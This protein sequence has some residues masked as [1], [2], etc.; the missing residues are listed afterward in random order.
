[1]NE[2][3]RVLV[4]DDDAEIRELLASTLRSRSLEVDRAHD[5]REALAMMRE[6]QYAVVLLD[7]LMP[8]MNGF[9]VLD[10]MDEQTRPV[11][12]VITGADQSTVEQLDSR[13]VHGVVRKPFDPH[14]LA[15]VVR[16]CAE[17]RGRGPLGAM[18]IATV[19]AGT[20]LFALISR[21]Q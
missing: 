13:I 15:E 3:K 9:E 17:I 10:E 14:E 6:N 18:A 8:E 2:Q 16:S 5:G 1:M 11:V 12:L 4:V 7:L 20:P 19:I 21:M